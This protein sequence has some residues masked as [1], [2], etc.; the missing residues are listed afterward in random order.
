MGGKGTKNKIPHTEAYRQKKR[1]ARIQF[2]AENPGCMSGENN[3]N[4][5][6]GITPEGRKRLTRLGWK[7]ICKRIIARDGECCVCGS[8]EGLCVHHIK[9][10]RWSG[11]DGD[12]NLITV[13]GKH[14]PQLDAQAREEAYQAAINAYCSQ[15]QGPGCTAGACALFPYRPFQ[16]D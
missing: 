5:R 14:H 9:P 16:G 10:W 7:A 6:G 3:P 12:D 2:L 4:W 1:A 8:K 15:C 13:C 11:D